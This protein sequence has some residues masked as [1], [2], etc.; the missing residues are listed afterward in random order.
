MRRRLVFGAVFAA[1]ALLLAACGNMVESLTERAVGEALS[2]DEQ[3]VDIDFDEGVTVTGEDGEQ[4]EV[5]FDEESGELSFSG[6]DGEMTLGGGELP[7]EFPDEFPLP[8]GAEVL[9]QQTQ[10]D[11][12]GLSLSVQLAVDAPFEETAGP[13]RDEVEAAGWDVDEGEGHDAGETLEL[14]G[15][16]VEGPEADVYALAGHGFDDGVLVILD[17]SDDEGDSGVVLQVG[18]ERDER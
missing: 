2:D 10:R 6:E 3:D 11:D 16:A 15:Q 18:F 8:E 9:G 5:S 13:L 7:D 4:S 17:V 14:D 12:D 1:L